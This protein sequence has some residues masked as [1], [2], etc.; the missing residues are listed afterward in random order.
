MFDIGLDKITTLI[1]V[2]S[3][4]ALVDLMAKL[5]PTHQLERKDSKSFLPAARVPSKANTHDEQ[6]SLEERKNKLIRQLQNVDDQLKKAKLE[7]SRL[8]AKRKS[9]HN[10]DD[11]Q[12]FNKAV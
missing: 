10:Y 5:Q 6:K 2:K 7:Q 12:A 9:Q 3:E 1:K 4:N 8:E 11:P